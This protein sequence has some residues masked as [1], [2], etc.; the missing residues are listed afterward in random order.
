[1]IGSMRV[2]SRESTAK[3]SERVASSSRFRI[4]ASPNSVVL[5]EQLFRLAPEVGLPLVLTNDLHYVR[6]DQRDAHDVLLCIGT[7][8]N[9]ETPGRMK[10][11]SGD[12]YI[13]VTRADGGALP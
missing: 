9:L 8:S 6:A 3:S 11:G 2:P 13:E 5:N 12:F 7:A 10:F 4:T 1:M